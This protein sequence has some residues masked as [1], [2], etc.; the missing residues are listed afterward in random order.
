MWGQRKRATILWRKEIKGGPKEKLS[1]NFKRETDYEENTNR[2][3]IPKE[4]IIVWGKKQMFTFSK[5]KAEKG[6]VCV[7]V[8]GGKEENCPPIPKEKEVEG[9]NKTTQFHPCCKGEIT[10]SSPIP[11]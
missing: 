11:S 3:P 1:C 7:C 6:C 2:A 9:K 5:G 4:R 8:C 10:N